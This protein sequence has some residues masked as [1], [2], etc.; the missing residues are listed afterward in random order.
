MKWRLLKRWISMVGAAKC[1][2]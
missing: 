2:T 1:L